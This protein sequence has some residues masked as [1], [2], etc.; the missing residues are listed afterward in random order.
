[1][2]N[3]FLVNLLFSLLLALSFFSCDKDGLEDHGLPKPTQEGK[4]IFAFLMNGEVWEPC[5]KPCFL[6][7]PDPKLY[8]YHANHRSPRID[9]TRHCDGID[10]YIK[11]AIDSIDPNNVIVG[12]FGI[13]YGNFGLNCDDYILDT[14]AV[15]SIVI[16]RY[17][18]TPLGVISG[19]FDFTLINQ[20]VLKDTIR[21]T[22]GRFDVK[23]SF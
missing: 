8:A 10:Q 3:I 19:T 15:N 1:M 18:A 9:A 23:T 7:P 5:V 4:G 20:C 11:I 16:T 6:C 12:G 13:L 22:N 21:I 17:D 14:S 2:R